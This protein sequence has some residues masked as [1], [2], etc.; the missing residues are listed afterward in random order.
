MVIVDFFIFRQITHLSVHHSFITCDCCGEGCVEVKCPYCKRNDT[1]DEALNNDPKFCIQLGSPNHRPISQ[2]QTQMNVCD[3]KG[4]FVW[5]EKDYFCRRVMQD[6]D[7]WKTS[8]EKAEL[9]VRNWVI[10]EIIRKC[11]T[12]VPIVTVYDNNDGPQFCYCKGAVIEM[13][14]CSPAVRQLKYF[15]LKCLNLTRALK[16]SCVS[17]L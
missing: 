14:P 1:V 2:I 15:H 13:Y 16:N 5:T 9:V 10:P 4:F 6:K 7:T 11:F 12:R 8:V 17:W 3:R